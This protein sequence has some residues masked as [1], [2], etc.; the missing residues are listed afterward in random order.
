MDEMIACL[1]DTDFRELIE[2][3]GE[4]RAGIAVNELDSPNWKVI[5]A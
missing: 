4:I 3:P 2:R 1:D 5:T